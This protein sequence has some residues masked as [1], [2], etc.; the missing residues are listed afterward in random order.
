MLNFPSFFNGVSAPYEIEQSLR[1]DG[2][3]KLSRT[4]S[5][6]SNRKRWTASVWMKIGWSDTTT[7]NTNYEALLSVQGAGADT[8]FN[9]I[10][11]R[12][13]D[14]NYGGYTGTFRRTEA[15]YRDVSAWY[16]FVIQVDTA[17]ASENDRIKL[18]VN[19]V[20]DTWDSTKQSLLSVTQNQD[21]AINQ[22]SVAHDIGYDANDNDYGNFY[23]AEYHL[24]DGQAL[25]HEDFGEFD[26]NGV[27]VPKEVTGLTYGT[28]GFYLKFDP[29]ATNGIGHDH[30]GNGN[31]FTPTGF[32]TSGTGTDVMSDTPTTNYCTWN[33]ITTNSSGIAL[34]E[35]N[36]F[37]VS[38]GSGNND[39]GVIGTIG[40]TSGKWY[41]EGQLKNFVG[42]RHLV[43]VTHSLE[44]GNPNLK[45]KSLDTGFWG[46]RIVNGSTFYI[47]EN[48]VQ[49]NT[50]APYPGSTPTSDSIM[51]FALDLDNLKWYIGFDGNWYNSG[52]PVAGTNAT[53][54]GLTSGQTWF[55]IC[56][57][58]GDED[59][60]WN[61]GQRAF[62]YTPPTGF[63]ALNTANLPAPDIA[64]G[65][66]YF[67]TVLWTG[68]GASSRS[69]TGV[70]FQPDWVWFKR[71]N[72]AANHTLYDVVRGATKTLQSSLPDAEVTLT[73]GL[74][75]FD[76]DGFT[77]GVYENANT[78][79]YVAWN[80]LAGGSGSSNT[81]GSITSTVSANPTAGF[82]VVTY[83]G[84]S[85][86]NDTIGHG[87]GVAPAMVIVK[88]RTSA[89]NGSAGSH[90]LTRHQA[91]G[92]TG[93]GTSCQLFLNLT[94]GLLNNDHGTLITSGNNLLQIKA[95]GSGIPY[96]HVGESGQN[97]VAYCFAEV[98]G[99]SKFGSY[100]GNFS[101]D[102]PFVYCGF[103]PAWV[104]R[105]ATTDTSNWVILDTARDT[106]NETDNMLLPN[107]SGSESDGSDIDILSNG[108]KMRSGAL[109][110]SGTTYIFAAFAE[111]PTGGS[112][113][114]PATAR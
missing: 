25:T 48:G 18:W 22:S 113:V 49:V 90:W 52:D 34:S 5:S 17:A 94:N 101:S 43:G 86:D 102:G 72:Q 57:L 3:S 98:E 10:Y 71:R 54:T 58:R 99:Y 87:L 84:T 6:A 28:N 97:Y 42:F 70:G 105:K 110:G 77:T 46:S 38:P 33:P 106:Y 92:M 108:F 107:T 16:H 27:W 68:D 73:N 12:T 51:Q 67:N 89:A 36:L 56:E 104:M 79:T 82:S 31:N 40:V 80:W 59:S 76:T 53:S 30:S 1:F 95:S 45:D 75:S 15:Y 4:P 14:L 19:G 74:T 21:L 29:S 69:T 85:T 23:L 109:N 63:N 62:E 96:F 24:V 50:S 112:G 37:V 44:A 111:H 103:R 9:R 61:F 83:S 114:S 39:Y 7:S 2:S 64:D 66:D 78:I 35:G 41:W 81:D 8:T 26:N 93:S 32:T 88:N 91:I 20:R 13:G 55:P 47:L 60:L 65:S 11:F 100:T